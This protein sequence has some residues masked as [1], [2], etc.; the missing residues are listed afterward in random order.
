VSRNFKPKEF[1]CPCCSISNVDPD[2]VEALEQ[3]RTEVGDKPVF[4]LS[5]CRCPQHNADVGGAEHSRHLTNG[6]RACDAVDVRVP[7]MTLPQLYFA[8]CKVKPFN[9]GGIGIY[10]DKG[11]IHLD[12]RPGRERWGHMAGRYVP[13]IVAWKVLEKEGIV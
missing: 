12:T 2:L 1:A 11:F 5:G 7:G 9:E 10:L 8:A 4:V 13:F 6:L 3:Y